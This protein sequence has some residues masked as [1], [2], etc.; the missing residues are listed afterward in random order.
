MTVLIAVTKLSSADG[1]QRP[2]SGVPVMAHVG[3]TPQAI[4]ALG[5]FR[6]QGRDPA[7]WGPFEDDARAVAESNALR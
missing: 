7:T 6:A 4:N 1:M 2:E 3:L 5:G